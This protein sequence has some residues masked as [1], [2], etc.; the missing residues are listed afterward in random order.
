MKL[1]K[2]DAFELVTPIVDG[3]AD[4][5]ERDAF[6]RYIETDPDVKDYYQ[7]ELWLKQ[8]V[9]V[10]VKY[11][12]APDY[13]KKKIDRIVTS[14]GEEEISKA[15]SKVTYGR[16]RGNL[17]SKSYFVAKYA[18]AAVLVL[19]A[20]AYL[21]QLLSS[22]AFES[23]PPHS[24]MPKLEQQVHTHFLE[25]QGRFITPDIVAD[26]TNDLRRTVFEQFGH[27]YYVPELTNLS[28]SGVKKSEFIAEYHTPLFQYKVAE[29]DYIYIYAFHIPE[30]ENHLLRN[31]DAVEFC[32]KD[33]KY[34]IAS[35][36]GK[37][38]VSWKWDEFW[39]VGISHHDGRELASML[40]Q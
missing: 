27:E 30:M 6:F 11:E 8:L 35:F 21:F 39:Y 37:D 1:E 40:P 14:L 24:A 31:T 5:Q 19:M 18:I 13:L 28:L 23:M 17:E 22:E 38:I 7:E 15:A 29:K 9:K 16:N 25:N 33:Y 20:F 32:I 36:E 26:G 2:R 12:P 10:R 3:E 34:H 4:E